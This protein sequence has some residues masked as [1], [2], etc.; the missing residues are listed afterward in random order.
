MYAIGVLLPGL[1]PLIP[2]AAVL[3][4]IRVTLA[5][6][7]IPTIAVAGLAGAVVYSAGYLAVPATAS[8]RALARRLLTLGRG[9]IA[10]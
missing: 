5:P 10:P 6:A 3:A 8:E 9:A 4:V 7:T 2:M 1:A